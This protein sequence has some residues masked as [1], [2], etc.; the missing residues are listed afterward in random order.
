M[1]PLVAD[2]VRSCRPLEG[3]RFPGRFGHDGS[4]RTNL[5]W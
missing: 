5:V 2:L 4:E 3:F 1:H